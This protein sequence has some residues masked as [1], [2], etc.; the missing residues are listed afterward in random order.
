MLSTIR[1]YEMSHASGISLLVRELRL[2]ADLRMQML[3]KGGHVR[4]V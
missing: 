1:D 3:H 2:H 4:Y